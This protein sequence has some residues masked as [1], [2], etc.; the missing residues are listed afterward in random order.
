MKW[1]FHHP[2]IPFEIPDS[3]QA[4]G[5]SLDSVSRQERPMCLRESLFKEGRP[6]GPFVN[7]KGTLKATVALGFRDI[8]TLQ[9]HIFSIPYKT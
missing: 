5:Q 7:L 2:V 6:M 4:L 3:N 8:Q 9:V 1:P